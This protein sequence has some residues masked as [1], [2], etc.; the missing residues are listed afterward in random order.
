MDWDEDGDL[1]LIL[2]DYK[3]E[4][5]YYKNIGTRST[6]KFTSAGRIQSGG[7]D[8]DVG[9]NA[10][11]VIVDWNNDGKKDLV[12]GMEDWQVRVYLNVNSN[13]APV[14]NGYTVVD[15]VSYFE[16]HPEVY[17]LNRD[18]KKDLIV[19]DNEGYVYFHENTASDEAPAFGAGVRLKVRDGLPI[20]V[21]LRAR[22]EVDDWNHDGKPDL[23]VGDDD[24][25]ITLYRNSGLVSSLEEGQSSPVAAY[26]LD[27]NYPNPF[28]GATRIE[29]S[30]VTSGIVTIEVFDPSG[31]Y[32][33]TVVSGWQD[34]GEHSVLWQPAALSSGLYLYKIKAGR[35]EAARKMFYIK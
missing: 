16:A 19:S 9:N 24:G 5:W 26:R 13:S 18:G 12:L 32:I 22:V 29:Y 10:A 17:D 21:I 8:I 25:Y 14:F 3:G 11:P 28:N 15:N 34:K 31:R 30:T 35:F 20:K 2:G 7:A 6:P 27:Q 1:D 33:D 4:V 23:L